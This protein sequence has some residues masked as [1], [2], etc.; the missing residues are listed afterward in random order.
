MMIPEAAAVIQFIFALMLTLVGVFGLY[1]GGILPAW[2][3]IAVGLIA[4]LLF[5]LLQEPA[6]RLIARLNDRWKDR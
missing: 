3:S 4:F 1:I 2:Q 6:N 5:A